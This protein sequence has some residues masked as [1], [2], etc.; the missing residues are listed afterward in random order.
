MNAIPARRGGRARGDRRLPAARRRRL[1]RRARSRR[2]PP[3]PRRRRARGGGH[4]LRHAHRPARGQDRRSRQPV[5]VGGQVDGDRRLRHR[6]LRRSDRDSGHG[7]QDPAGVGG[8]G[9]DR[10]GR[11]RSRCP[12]RLHRHQ[13]R[14]WPSASRPRSRLQLPEDGPARA[15]LWKHGGIIV[16]ASTDEA[17]ELANA[18]ASEHLVVESDA[19]AA[20]IDNA[21]AVF[22]GPWTAQVA[23]DYAIGSNHVLPTAGAARY[24]GGLNA[25]DFVK[26]IS[27]QRVSEAGPAP[28]SLVRSPRSPAP[29]GSRATRGRSRDGPG[30]LGAQ[31]SRLRA[32]DFCLCP[33]DL[34]LKTSGPQDLRTFRGAHVHDHPGRSR[35]RAPGCGCT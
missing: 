7:G 6:L 29:K 12:R 31:A 19:V 13:P 33:Q 22:V 16:A 18:C 28:P 20:R 27:V 5:G 11:A 10:A 9:P 21:G 2:G 8:R 30:A 35:S 25:A 14:R 1:R 3:L 24:R 4:G 23:G 15:S 32:S 17:I 34:C 26:L